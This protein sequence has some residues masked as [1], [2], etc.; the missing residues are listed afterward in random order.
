MRDIDPVGGYIKKELFVM[1]EEEKRK[2]MDRL[3]A[4]KLKHERILELIQIELIKL[5]Q[6]GLRH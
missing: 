5:R 1:T 2:E 6:D 4:L 3:L